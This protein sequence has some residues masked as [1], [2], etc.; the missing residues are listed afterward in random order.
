MK[1]T[2]N[3]R[4][5]WNSQHLRDSDNHRRFQIDNLKRKKIASVEV[6]WG[7][8]KDEGVYLNSRNYPA[9]N[10]PAE[11]EEH[12]NLDT[13]FKNKKNSRS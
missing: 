8:E 13:L 10:C 9:R 11:V 1:P 3:F 2:Q 7:R 12:R 4:P 5:Y 6:K